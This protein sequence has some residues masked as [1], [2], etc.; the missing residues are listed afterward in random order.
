MKRVFLVLRFSPSRSFLRGRARG[1]LHINELLRA[2]LARKRLYTARRCIRTVPRG[3]CVYPLFGGAVKENKC[4]RLA[5][6]NTHPRNGYRFFSPREQRETAAE[7]LCRYTLYREHRGRR[8]RRAAVCVLQSHVRG[9]ACV[10]GNLTGAWFSMVRARGT[11]RGE[12]RVRTRK[13]RP[14]LHQIASGQRI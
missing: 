12:S 11:S 7:A 3:L 10:H 9:G 1:H 8:R 6:P 5:H 2:P 13:R 4:A 14:A